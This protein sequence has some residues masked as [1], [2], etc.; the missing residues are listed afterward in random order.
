MTTGPVSASPLS[1]EE[2]L[3]I[4]ASQNLDLLQRVGALEQYIQTSLG[5]WIASVQSFMDNEAAAEPVKPKEEVTSNPASRKA[6]DYVTYCQVIA[7][8]EAGLKNVEIAAKLGIKAST[9]STYKSWQDKPEKIAEA[10]AKAIA[11]GTY[12]EGTTPRAVPAETATQP[13][14]SVATAEQPTVVEPEIT[15]HQDV[16]YITGYHDIHG[17]HISW[18]MPPNVASYKEIPN[19]NQ[20]QHFDANGKYICFSVKYI[21]YPD[22]N[23][24]AL[25]APSASPEPVPTAPAAGG[26][27]PVADPGVYTP[28]PEG[29]YGPAVSATPSTP[30]TPIM[31]SGAAVPQ[32]LPNAADAAA[33]VYGVLDPTRQLVGYM[34]TLL[35]DGTGRIFMFPVYAGD[36]AV[37]YN[38]PNFVRV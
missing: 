14:E 10:K 7:L 12:V 32:G 5:P 1:Y 15:V 26:Y 27:D 2:R 19:S 28:P 6:T 17:N 13:T 36:T 9:V 29:F 3:N 30:A 37:D 33:P 34:Q 38:S 21:R 18:T 16:E 22:G 4:I 25:P 23:V 24:E 8:V 11:N 35:Q 31:M 20:I